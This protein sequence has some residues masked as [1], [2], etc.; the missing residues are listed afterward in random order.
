MALLQDVASLLF[1]KL[2][3]VEDRLEVIE[4]KLG[5]KSPK[6]RTRNDDK[7]GFGNA[8]STDDENS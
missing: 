7:S 2:T 3:K 6:R 1:F 5:I 8:R 4:T